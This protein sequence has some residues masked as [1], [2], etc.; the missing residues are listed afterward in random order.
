M[1]LPRSELAEINPR[2]N[3]KCV[4]DAF[5]AFA[6]ETFLREYPQLHLF[7]TGGK[8]GAIDLSQTSDDSRVVCECKHVGADE[9][10]TVQ[11]EWRT[12]AKRLE[13]HLADPSGPTRGQSQYGPWYRK[14]PAI[15]EFISARALKSKTRSTPTG[16][17]TKSPVSFRH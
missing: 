17:A 12:V 4:G 1:N 9:L 13:E 7:P 8:D 3:H 6:Y 15:A 2:L 11:A 10:A 16:Y 5:Q 14:A